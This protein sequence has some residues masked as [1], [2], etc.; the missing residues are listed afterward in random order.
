MSQLSLLKGVARMENPFSARKICAVTTPKMS[1]GHLRVVQVAENRFDDAIHHLKW[2]FFSDEPL[3]HAVGLCERGESQYE[4][5][6]HCLLTLK[7]GYSR[8]LVDQN[9]MYNVYELFEC[10]ILS[11]DENFRGKGLAN[12]LMADS[13]ETARNAGFKVF[14]ADATGM[15]SQKVCLKHG[16]QV[17]AEIP[18]TDLDESIRPAPPHQALKL[19]VKVLN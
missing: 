8:M 3:N 15:F 14:K 16:F 17:E 13:I 1:S 7:Q 5:E 6:R 18:Y 4:L 9:G 2:N 12:V 10:R 19:M 11:V